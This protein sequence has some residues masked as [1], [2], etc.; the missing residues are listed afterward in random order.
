METVVESEE[1]LSGRE[2]KAGLSGREPTKVGLIL[3]Q[4]AAPSRARR[5]G[6]SRVYTGTGTV[7]H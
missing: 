7:A 1:T 4:G 2:K 6:G 3:D 5:R